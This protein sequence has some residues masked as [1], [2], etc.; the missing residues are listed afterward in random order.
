MK[1]DIYQLEQETQEEF[2]HFEYH[3]QSDNS[4]S[5]K[6]LFGK[7][8]IHY[9]TNDCACYKND[10]QYGAC[11][12]NAQS[13]FFRAFLSCCFLYVAFYFFSVHCD[14]PVCQLRERIL[15]I[16]NSGGF[17]LFHYRLF[18]NFS[19]TGE[20]LVDS[21]NGLSSELAGTP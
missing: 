6:S 21:V 20:Y 8:K 18:K 2:N 16:Y 4:H 12:I 14:Y 9:Q 3:P 19:R 5:C 13:V 7:G 11:F 10:V 15:F 17:R 1:N